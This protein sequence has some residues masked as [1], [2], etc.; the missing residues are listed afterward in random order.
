M[1]TLI[2][3]LAMTIPAQGEKKVNYQDHVLPVLQ[4]KCANCHSTDKKRGGLVVTN[5]TKLME[6]GSSGVVVKPGDP[7]NSSLFNTVAHKVEPFMP[8]KSPKIADAEIAI[9]EGWISAGAPETSGSKVMAVAKKEIGLKSVVRG[10]P[11]GPPPMPSK[12]LPQEPVTKTRRA[13]P[14]TAIASNPWSPLVAVGGLKQV[15]LYHADTQE[16][17]GML[18]FPEGLP[19]VLKFSRNGGLLLVAGGRG[20]A[21]GKVALFNVQTGERITTVGEE[22]DTVL[23]A[24]ISPDQSLIAL[25]GP[26]KMLRVYNTA[27]GKLVYEVKKHTDWITALEFSPDGVLLATGDRSSGMYVWES[28]NGREYFT[29]RG[30]GGAITELSWR[31]DSNILLSGSEDGTVRQWEM[32]NG[33]QVRSWAA[34][35]GGVLGARYGMDGR[36]VSAG[37]D[38]TVKLWDGNGGA[39]RS[40]EAL[41]DLALRATL[42]HDGTRVLGTDWTGQVVEWTAIDGKRLGV[43]AANPGSLADRLALAAKELE[44]KQ[45]ALA[46]LLVQA[47]QADDV[48]KQTSAAINEVVALQKTMP[49]QIELL[50]AG[51][52][53]AKAAKDALQSSKTGLEMDA[54]GREVVLLELRGMLTRLKDLAQKAPA[55]KA[56]PLAA[57]RAQALVVLIEQEAAPVATKLKELEPSLA[58]ETKAQT[59]AEGQLAALTVQLAA[60]PKRLVDMQAA[61]KT[62]TDR[63]KAT[64]VLAQQAQVDFD[65]AKAIVDRLKA[66]Q[67]TVSTQPAKAAGS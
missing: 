15:L 4:A 64:Q 48:M 20:S 27:D 6:G 19:T 33:G 24:D 61:Q 65:V 63:V 16:L 40:F 53:K 7:S 2:T 21:T 43:L 26:S 10:R 35:G 52:A 60:L 9:I 34:H 41:P 36:I 29:L 45:A 22:T 37:R 30:H 56:L 66:R 58:R 13:N 23:A 51:Q 49:P 1:N 12:P 17:L 50:K 46:P 18:P 5:Y 67:A 28:F 42:T 14:V 62:A 44:K 11:E 25:G 3:L 57:T 32:E 38:R 39:V 55:D 54:K 47:R 31:Q 8:P 59:D